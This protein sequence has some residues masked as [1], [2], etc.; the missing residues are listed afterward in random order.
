MKRVVMILFGVLVCSIA[1]GMV[2]AC[3]FVEGLAD[4]HSLVMRLVPIALLIG[5]LLIQF[6]LEKQRGNL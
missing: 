3:F 5:V 6:G 4:P 2:I 1:I